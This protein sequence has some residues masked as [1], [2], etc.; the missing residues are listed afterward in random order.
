LFKGELYPGEHPRIVP[1]DLFQNVQAALNAQ[2]PGETARTK[3]PS[4]SLLKGLV[5]DEAGIPLQVSH[6]N[7]K[8]RKYRYY[9]S[10]TK[11]RGPTQAGDGFRIPASDMEKVVVQSLARYLRDQHWLDQTFKSHVDVTRF[12]RFTS[13]AG[14]LANLIEEELAQSTSLM[15]TIIDRIVVAQK[16]ITIKVQ[17]NRLMSL[18]LGRASKAEQSEPPIEIKVFGQ[19]I[20]CGKEVRLVIGQDDA[21]DAKVDS[22]LVQEIIQARQWFDDLANR[23]VASIAD[24][25]RLSGISAPYISKKIS[26]AF[27]APGI[28]EMIVTGT[29]PIRLTPEKLKRA[30]PLSVSW[31]EQRA[32]LII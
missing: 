32:L 3:R 6:T 16:T 7:K 23:R 18:L 26:L 4:T 31:D 17:P 28:T 29:Q 22:R 13:L 25:A 10:A 27:L 14:N 11:M 12:Q 2:G 21:K 15:P 9:V 1:E 20:R 5:F 8:G 19:F 24:L 30:C